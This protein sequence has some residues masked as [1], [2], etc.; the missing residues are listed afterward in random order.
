M[1]SHFLDYFSPLL[2]RRH[3]ATFALPLPALRCRHADCFDISLYL[4][5][6]FLSFHFTFQRY[7]FRH[8]FR[9]IERQL[10]WPLPPAADEGHFAASFQPL[11]LRGR[12]HLRP[13][14]S[15]M[16]LPCQAALPLVCRYA[17]DCQLSTVC[18]PPAS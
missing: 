18:Q 2:S 1:A 6:H 12:R 3:A 4:M 7:R 15:L 8:D 14:F 11:F 9:D 5:R 10:S 13:L 16:I 17:A